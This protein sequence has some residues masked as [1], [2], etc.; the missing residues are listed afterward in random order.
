MKGASLC[1]GVCRLF[2]GALEFPRNGEVARCPRGRSTAGVLFD[3]VIVRDAREDEETRYFSKRPCGERPLLRHPVFVSSFVAT[4]WS[5]RIASIAVV[6]LSFLG[7]A[8]LVYAF[9]RR[10]ERNDGTA[11]AEASDSIR[12][13]CIVW[14]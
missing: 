8:A 2:H 5:N 11:G 12:G 13:S 9:Y 4:L 10:P 1:P 14:W 3:V 7:A 6:W